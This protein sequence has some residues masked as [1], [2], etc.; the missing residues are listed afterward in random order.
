M[1]L[2]YNIADVLNK[3]GFCLAVWACASAESKA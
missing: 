2:I 3:I 1:N